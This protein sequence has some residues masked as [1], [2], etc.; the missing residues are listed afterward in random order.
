MGE[1]EEPANSQNLQIKVAEITL[2]EILA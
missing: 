2:D 1:P